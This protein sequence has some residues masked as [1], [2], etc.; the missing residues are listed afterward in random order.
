ME[1]LARIEPAAAAA[2]GILSSS[3][4][5][6]DAVVDGATSENRTPDNLITSEVLYR[7]S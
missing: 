1:P 4:L 2:G 6:N 7:L 3:F 5:R